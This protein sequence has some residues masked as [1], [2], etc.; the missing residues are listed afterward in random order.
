MTANHESR[1]LGI[2]IRLIR[3]LIENRDADAL[4]VAD[5]DALLAAMEAQAAADAELASFV[6]WAVLERD[7]GRL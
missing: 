2:A 4:L 1:F 7:G 6:R 5:F 3:V